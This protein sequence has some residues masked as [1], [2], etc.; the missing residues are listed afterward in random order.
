MTAGGEPYFIGVIAAGADV[1]TG[2]AQKQSGN[3]FLDTMSGRRMNKD[4]GGVRA[5]DLPGLG[6]GIP[7]HISESV[8]CHVDL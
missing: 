1:E 5:L 3:C 7:A 2:D 6:A 8:V 4:T